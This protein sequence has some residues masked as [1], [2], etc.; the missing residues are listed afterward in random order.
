MRMAQVT[1]AQVC[2]RHPLGDVELRNQRDIG[3]SSSVARIAA[4]PAFV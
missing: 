4:L 1:A 3:R 2:G